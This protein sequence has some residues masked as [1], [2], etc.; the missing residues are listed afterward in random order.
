MQ[1]ETCAP[2]VRAYEDGCDAIEPRHLVP[3]P[4]GIAEAILRGDPTR[5]YPYVKAMVVESGGDFVSVTENEIREARRMTEELEGVSP[6]FSAST[7]VAGLIK[8]VRAGK[9]PRGDTVLVNLTGGD[10]PRTKAAPSV[11]WLRRSAD[12]WVEEASAVP[13]G[14]G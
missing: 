2:L 4:R 7:A 13:A 8:Q 11:R 1:Q 14:S 5:V 3:R 6:C 9:F 10:R 12:K